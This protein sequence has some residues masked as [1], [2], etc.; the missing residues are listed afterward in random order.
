MKAISDEPFVAVFFKGLAILSIIGGIFQMFTGGAAGIVTGLYSILGAAPLAWWMGAVLAL[1][2]RIATASETRAE[3]CPTQPAKS[4]TAPPASS[5]SIL[6]AV[7]PMGD[8]STE[9]PSYKI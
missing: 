8:A 7:A 1:L 3:G 2:H 4:A 9:V 5:R 6:T